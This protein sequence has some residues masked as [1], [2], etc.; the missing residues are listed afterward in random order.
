MKSRNEPE[1]TCS[2]APFHGCYRSSNLRGDATQR[3]ATTR[4]SGGS[5]ASRKTGVTDCVTGPILALLSL[6]LTA[7]CA[8]DTHTPC[9][10][11]VDDAC[12]SAPELEREAAQPPALLAAAQSALERWEERHGDAPLCWDE[13]PDFGWWLMP[14]PGSLLNICE[15]VGGLEPDG[16]CFYYVVPPVGHRYPRVALLAD[17]TPEQHGS[18]LARW[19]DSC[20]F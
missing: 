13:L 6:L 17:A 14:E 4:Q 1:S 18:K 12:E 2:G 19:L 10:A 11:G 7:S 15:D 5:A 9:L 20:A 3:R 16:G 8:V